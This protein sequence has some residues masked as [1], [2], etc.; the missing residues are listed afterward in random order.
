MGILN[1]T[2]DSFSDGGRHSSL[3]AQVEAALA[4][5]EAGADII[6]IGGESTRPGAAAVS[7]AEE[8]ARV[9]PVVEALVQSGVLASKAVRLSIDTRH[10]AT[11]QAALQAGA[12]HTGPHIFNDVSALCHD[13]AALA[14]AVE[15]RCPVVLMH[16]ADPVDTLHHRATENG[17][18]VDTAPVTDIV[19][20]VYTWFE[21]HI[22]AVTQAGVL[23]ENII[24]DPGIGFGKT[25]QENVELV[26]HLVK[27]KEFG[28]PLLFGASR[29]RMIAHIAGDCPTYARLGG[30]LA[31][32]LAAAQ[33]G[34]DII[35]VHDVA[36]T[37]QALKIWQAV[38]AE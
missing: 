20:R 34:A 33:A 13:P 22:A 28:L 4:M 5:V 29:K 30:S 27:F 7:A 24:L 1:V 25:A 15:A 18:P 37:A 2:P 3:A 26:R 23:A 35:R 32:A 10:A 17:A 38:Q 21:A 6:D 31:L 36:E 16:S 8:Q 9:L 12:L 19:A 11:M 14:L